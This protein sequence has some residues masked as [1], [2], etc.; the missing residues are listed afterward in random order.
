MAVFYKIVKPFGPRSGDEWR[1]YIEWT[2]QKSIDRFD[3][4]D[5]MLRENCFEPKTE[6][7]WENCVNENFKLNLLTSRDYALKVKAENPGSEMIGVDIEIDGTYQEKEGCLGYDVVDRYCYISL[8]T[9]WGNN[10]SDFRNVTFK[11]NGLVGD[12][13]EAL[14]LRDKLRAEHPMDE[15]ASGCH[16]W[17]IYEVSP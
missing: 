16:V 17:A 10:E 3:S 14:T 5:G 11:N 7:D 8:I 9:N 4:A 12:L 2:Q 13:R 1:K 15:H 6:E